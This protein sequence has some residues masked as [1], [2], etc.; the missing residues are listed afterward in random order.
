MKRSDSFDTL[1]ENIKRQSVKKDKN[2]QENTSIE[3]E[4][5][6]DSDESDAQIVLIHSNRRSVSYTSLNT[7]QESYSTENNS[8]AQDTKQIEEENSEGEIDSVIFNF[9]KIYFILRKKTK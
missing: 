8:D 6:D 7:D 3:R 2:E 9:N 1:N 5:K 4:E